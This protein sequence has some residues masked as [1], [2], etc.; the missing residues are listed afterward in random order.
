VWYEFLNQLSS[1]EIERTYLKYK[2][3][4]NTELTYIE[5]GDDLYEI[6]FCLTLRGNWKV[7]NTVTQF[8]RSLKRLETIRGPFLETQVT[9]W[10]LIGADGT[11]IP[12]ALSKETQG[13]MTLAVDE[14]KT[15]KKKVAKYV[16]I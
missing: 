14:A 8:S 12:D 10:Q 11:E 1:D 7:L 2:L 15:T 5:C 13:A 9:K 3:T 4:K 6:K 16:T